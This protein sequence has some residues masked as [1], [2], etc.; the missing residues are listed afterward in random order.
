MDGRAER[1]EKAFLS[2]PVLNLPLAPSISPGGSRFLISTAHKE[3]DWPLLF[4]FRGFRLPRSVIHFPSGAVSTLNISLIFWHWFWSTLI[5][6][7][8]D[9]SLIFWHWFWSTLWVHLTFILEYSV[10]EGKRLNSSIYFN[11]HRSNL[12]CTSWADSLCSTW[13]IALVTLF[14]SL[15]SQKV[16]FRKET[17]IAYLPLFLL[18]C[19]T[20][21]AFN[22]VS[23]SIVAART[24]NCI[25]INLLKIN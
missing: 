23:K 19:V 16:P 6:F 8:F 5:D 2:F 21:E 22:L 25:L 13:H 15:L 9:I 3:K 17:V 1:L 18:S 7:D 4:L 11:T 10:S 12:K 24:F 14:Y 20:Q